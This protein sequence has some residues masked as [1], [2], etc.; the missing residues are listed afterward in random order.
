MTKRGV[1]LVGVVIGAFTLGMHTHVYGDANTLNAGVAIDYS[2]HWN[3]DAS[4][5]SACKVVG[6]EWRGD[7]GAFMGEC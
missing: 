4:T 2:G 3:E 5:P 6:V 1:V 7:P